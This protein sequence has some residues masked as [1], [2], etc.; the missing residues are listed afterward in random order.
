MFV[1]FGVAMLGMYILLIFQFRSYVQAFII[2]AIIPFAWVGA[3]FGHFIVGIDLTLFSFFGLVALT[4]VVVNDSIVLIDF[5]N[6]QVRGGMPLHE[7]LTISGRRRFRPILLTSL[8]TIAGL[9][10]ILSER[11]MQAQVIIPMAVSLAF[12]LLATTFLALV[13]VPVLYQIY[14]IILSW[15]GYHLF[16]EDQGEGGDGEANLPAPRPQPP[17]IL[18][19]GEP[20]LLPLD[21]PHSTPANG[22]SLEKESSTRKETSLV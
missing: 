18:L 5:I 2:M 6:R 11:S 10:P 17:L 9:L 4:G 21:S 7:A 20:A 1:G 14:G 22:S 15:F 19:D 3:V 16:E 8:T 12:G 13:M